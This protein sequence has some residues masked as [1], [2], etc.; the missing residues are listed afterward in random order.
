MGKEKS[1]QLDGVTMQSRIV[2]LTNT[3]RDLKSKVAGYQRSNANYRTQI[4]ALK[5][6]IE[7]LKQLNKEGDELYEKRLAEL[8]AANKEVLSLK[9]VIDEKEKVVKGLQEQVNDVI[10]KKNK[11]E[12]EFV[13]CTRNLEKAEK[14]L[15]ELEKPWWKRIF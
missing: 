5:K 1:K 12:A 9:L 11:L 7:H 15:S 6:N 10:R 8:D 2:E 14:K 3:V 4:E 13:A